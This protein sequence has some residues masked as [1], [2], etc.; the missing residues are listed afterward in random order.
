[1]IKCLCLSLQS[2]VVELGD[3]GKMSE[4]PSVPAVALKTMG[5][6]LWT[7]GIPSVR[8]DASFF[9]LWWGPRSVQGEENVPY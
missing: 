7:T 1:M 9:N 4:K 6:S 3:R 8:D 2:I 5:F